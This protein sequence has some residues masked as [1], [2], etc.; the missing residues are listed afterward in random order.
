M[1]SGYG[2]YDEE[3]E[4]GYE[5]KGHI[6]PIDEVRIPITYEEGVYAWKKLKREGDIARLS[7]DELSALVR[8]ISYLMRSG[9]IR[10]KQLGEEMDRE[11]SKMITTEKIIE[12][13]RRHPRLA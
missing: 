11:L 5:E 1:L 4:E 10:K 2:E 3:W 12:I 9:D 13:R 6:D 8:L 7:I